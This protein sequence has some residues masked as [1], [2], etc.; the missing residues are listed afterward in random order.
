MGGLSHLIETAHIANTQCDPSLYA[1]EN[2]ALARAVEYIAS[3]NLGNDVPYTAKVPYTT[4]WA[5]IYDEISSNGRGSFQP[6]YELPYS[7]FHDELGMEMPYSL[8][9]IGEKGSELFSPQNDNPT[10]ATLLYRR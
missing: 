7:Y 5:D 1:W 6:I 9:G 3:Y 4:D 8:Q 10:F 2:Y